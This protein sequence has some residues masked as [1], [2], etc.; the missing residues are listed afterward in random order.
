MVMRRVRVEV[1]CISCWFY[2]STCLLISRPSYNQP[3]GGLLFRGSTQV[4]L[5]VFLF[6]CRSV[7]SQLSLLPSAER[8]VSSSYGYGVKA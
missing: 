3:A 6:V 1:Y 8:E 5:S 7:A 4:S 2:L